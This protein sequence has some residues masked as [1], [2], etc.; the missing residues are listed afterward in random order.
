MDQKQAS[1]PSNS[2]S[3]QVSPRFPDSVFVLCDKTYNSISS[4]C[5]T[6]FAISPRHV[7]T[8]AHNLRK[9]NVKRYFIA[10]MVTRNG[11]VQYPNGFH[12]VELKG[13]CYETDWAILELI[14]KSVSLKFI[15]IFR[16]DSIEVESDIKVYHA[17]VSFFNTQQNDMLCANPDWVKYWRCTRHHV[18]VSKGLFSGS[19]GSPF[20]LRNGQV[21][22]MH[23]ESH[24]EA[25]DIDEPSLKK[26]IIAKDDVWDVITVVSDSV[27]SSGR[28][29]AS[30]AQGLWLSKCTSLMTFLDANVLV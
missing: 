6:A 27:I 12:E 3:S 14:S 11:S 21:V 15:E 17:P 4:P 9:G 1:A 24:N 28:V 16:G 22:G 7:L 23:Q 25:V 29:H 8:C 18:C 19:S 20:L 2:S 26:R 5:G 13:R 30:M 10:L